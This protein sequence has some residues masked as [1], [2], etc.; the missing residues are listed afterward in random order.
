MTHNLAIGFLPAPVLV[1]CNSPLKPKSQKPIFVVDYTVGSEIQL[2][3]VAAET[4]A[5]R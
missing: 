5:R 3:G 4:A 2:F 1:A